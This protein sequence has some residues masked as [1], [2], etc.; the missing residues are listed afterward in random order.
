M[1]KLDASY[2]EEAGLHALPAGESSLLL[3]HVYNLLEMRVGTVLAGQMT[4]R[5]LD[6]FEK[7][8]DAENEAGALRWLETNFPDYKDTVAKEFDVLTA[9]LRQAAP[10]ILVLLGAAS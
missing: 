4:D 1:L 6:E 5:Q 8:I 2:L 9:E 7:F 10:T 3:K